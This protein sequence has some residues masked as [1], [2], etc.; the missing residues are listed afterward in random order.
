M[1]PDISLCKY[2][3]ECSE[4][5]K[6]QFQNFIPSN[7]NP[8]DIATRSVSTSRLADMQWFTGPDFL[9]KP[10]ST[11]QE[12]QGTLELVKPEMDEDIRP[13]V[14]NFATLMEEGHLTAERFKRFS[15]W[16]ALLRSIALLIHIAH[17]FKASSNAHSHEC[18]GWHLCK[19]ARTPEELS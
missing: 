5:V 1:R 14:T 15:S 11:H 16:K 18:K 19:M 10:I 2:I 17:S 12:T 13:H 4:F 3:T 6:V 8:A 7:Q 9:H